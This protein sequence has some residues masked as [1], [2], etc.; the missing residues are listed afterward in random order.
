MQ[1]N[2]EGVVLKERTVGGFYMKEDGYSLS[3]IRFQR[4]QVES[5]W[6]SGLPHPHGG[7]KDF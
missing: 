3:E 1:A 2:P 7:Q 4:E 6:R 5:S